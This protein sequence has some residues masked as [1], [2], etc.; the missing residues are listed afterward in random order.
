MATFADIEQVKQ[1][2][3][4]ILDEQ[5][6]DAIGHN[7]AVASEAERQEM[8]EQI[9]D[10]MQRRADL[11]RLAVTAEENSPQLEAALQGLESATDDMNEAAGRMKATSEFLNNAAALAG[12]A[13][14][15]ITALQQA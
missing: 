13:D 12:A 3:L 5:I 11:F 8:D 2:G 1:Q 10:L 4:A 14:Q 7:N 15:A 9:H 6:M